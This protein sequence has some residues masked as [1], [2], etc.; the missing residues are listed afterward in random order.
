MTLI[1]ENDLSALNS[2]NQRCSPQLLANGERLTHLSEPISHRPE[3]CDD[4]CLL[5]WVSAVSSVGVE[6]PELIKVLSYFSLEPRAP[7]KKKGSISFMMG[8]NSCRSK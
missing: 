8:R 2:G 3:K 6:A 4:E 5:H 1:R 7:T